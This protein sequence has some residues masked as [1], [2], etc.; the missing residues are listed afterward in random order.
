MISSVIDRS[1]NRSPAIPAYREKSSGSPIR[2]WTWCGRHIREPIGFTLSVP[3][4]ATGI[5]G[6]AGLQRHPGHAGLALVEPAVGRPGALRVD[7]EQLALAEQPDRRVERGLRAGRAG[8]VD[9]HLPDPGEEDL[10]EPAD[11]PGL[12]EVLA[13]GEERDAAPHQ[14]RQQERVGDREM[15]AG[16]DRGTP[17]AGCARDPRSSAGPT[18]ASAGRAAR[19]ST[20]STA[21]ELRTPHVDGDQPRDVVPAV[22]TGI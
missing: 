12:G 14:Q 5:T 9:R 4:I 13:L 17:L 22:T 10:L 7:A 2:M 6:T 15:V 1:M 8:A 20:T 3:I 19:T 16:E 11:Q 21:P 18:G